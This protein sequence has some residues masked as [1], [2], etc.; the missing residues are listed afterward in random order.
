VAV[1]NK[2]RVLVLEDDPNIGLLLTENLRVQGFEVA[3]SQDG[4]E[5]LEILQHFR[6]HVILSDLMVPGLSGLD[7][8]ARIRRDLK[9]NTPVVMITAKSQESDVVKALHLGAD[10]YIA[11][12]FSLPE[13]LARLQRLL[14]RSA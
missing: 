4:E 11:K 5:A 9:L 13:L 7:F 2:N 10:D 8:L 6:P 1:A 14:G 3:W 12:P